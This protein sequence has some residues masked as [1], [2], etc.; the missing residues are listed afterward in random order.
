MAR[1]FFKPRLL[2]T[3]TAPYGITD[4]EPSFFSLFSV[5]FPPLYVPL[6]TPFSFSGRHQGTLCVG[7]YV[8][9]EISSSNLYSLPA[10][11]R[12]KVYHNKIDKSG[13]VRKLN[14]KQAYPPNF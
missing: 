8:V 12:D 10:Q 4:R 13:H 1:I 9:Q 14:F 2:Y 7:K 6:P 11:A 3:D 5:S